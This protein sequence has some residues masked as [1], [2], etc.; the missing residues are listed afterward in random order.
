MAQLSV[1]PPRAPCRVSREHDLTQDDRLLNLSY[2]ADLASRRRRLILACTGGV[3]LSATAFS[4]SRPRIYEAVST[5]L[6]TGPPAALRV[7]AAA[8]PTLF[9]GETDPPRYTSHYAT[10][11]HAHRWRKTR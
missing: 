11:P 3:L 4:V 5:L 6:L 9:D 8:E 1:R 2:W 7:D 10:C